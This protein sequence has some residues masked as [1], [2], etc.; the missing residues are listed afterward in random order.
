M[1]DPARYGRVLAELTDLVPYGEIYEKTKV[2]LSAEGLVAR[3]LADDGSIVTY[4]A[5]WSR[6]GAYVYEP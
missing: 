2:R 6:D 1:G 3:T 5:R 4:R